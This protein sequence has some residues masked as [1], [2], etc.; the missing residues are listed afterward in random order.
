MQS[1]ECEKAQE[2]GKVGEEIRRKVRE[3][4]RESRSNFLGSSL[5][6]ESVP[7]FRIAHSCFGQQIAETCVLVCILLLL[8]V[9]VCVCLFSSGSGNNEAR[10]EESCRNS[11]Q[12]A[13]LLMGS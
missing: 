10:D 8:F 11:S 9:C 5:R 12:S 2:Q 7:G 1:G 13:F 6:L 4:S 3:E